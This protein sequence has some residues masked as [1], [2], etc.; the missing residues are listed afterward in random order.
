MSEKHEGK[1]LKERLEATG[2][3]I[4]R[5]A[6][7]L[8]MTRQNLNYHLRKE[9]L[10][11]T[12]S[13][14]VKKTIFSQYKEYE[15][16]DS[17]TNLVSEPKGVY[18]N[19]NIIANAMQYLMQVP[20][21]NQYAYAGYTRGFSDHEYVESLPKYP[22]IVDKEYKGTYRTFEVRG[23]SMDDGSRDSYIEGDKVLGRE[24]TKDHW[25]N[26]LH[27]RKWDFIIVHQTEGILLKRIIDHD[28][29]RGIITIHSL[30]DMYPDL[31][32]KLKDISQL[33]NVVQVARRK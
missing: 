6:E 19:A 25:K 13:D 28:T 2:L 3:P 20:L 15:L 29:E 32:L 12:F 26:K 7:K 16:S 23:D 24:I 10:D 1:A 9:V 18:S 8:K 21:V 22:W 27:I 11:T 31:K 5:I 30:N 17:G 14:L 33:F 4:I